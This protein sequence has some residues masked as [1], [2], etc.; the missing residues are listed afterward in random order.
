MDF[1]GS[2]MYQV[3]CPNREA[4]YYGVVVQRPLGT[5]TLFLPDKAMLQPAVSTS[6]RNMLWLWS[7]KRTT[8][9]VQSREGH[10]YVQFSIVD[11]ALIE[12]IHK[13]LLDAK[14]IQSIHTKIGP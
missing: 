12:I 4:A 13:D 6:G 1:L 8:I 9:V 7:I 5:G 11:P 14:I 2:R 3:Y 10:K